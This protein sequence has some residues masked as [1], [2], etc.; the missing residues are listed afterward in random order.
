MERSRQRCGQRPAV[1]GPQCSAHPQC[2]PARF[3]TPPA[4]ELREGDVV[5]VFLESVG[6]PEGDFLVSGVQA[7]VQRRMA[8]VWNEL[9]ERKARGELVKGEPG[10]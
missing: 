8:A 1:P 10:A 3:P 5:Q 6:T 7:A 9:E 4:G 2:L